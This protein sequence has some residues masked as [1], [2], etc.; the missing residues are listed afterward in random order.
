MV[1]KYYA[2]RKGL[3]CGIFRTWKECSKN[4]IG[5][6]GAQY[7]SFKTKEEAENYMS[8]KVIKV[9][10]EE[11]EIIRNAKNAIIVYTDGGYRSSMGKASIGIHFP[12]HEFEDISDG[13]QGK[14][15]NNRAE[16]SA[17][18]RCLETVKDCDKDVII[19]TDSEYSINCITGVKIARINLDLFKKIKKL[20]QGKKNEDRSV[21]FVWTKGHKGVMDGNYYA[22]KLCNDY[23]NKFL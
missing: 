6:S 4:V 7:K 22:D 23:L 11:E 12:N 2:V 9:V 18:V 10:K 5:F 16:L 20:I 14:Q 13:I 19:F 1:K 8:N 17:I 15:T 21:K 3:V